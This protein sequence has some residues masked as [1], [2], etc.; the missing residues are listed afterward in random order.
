MTDS[1]TQDYEAHDAALAKRV[2]RALSGDADHP[3]VEISINGAQIALPEAIQLRASFFSTLN[4]K[5]FKPY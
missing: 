3:I 5:Q 1:L 4:M 2:D